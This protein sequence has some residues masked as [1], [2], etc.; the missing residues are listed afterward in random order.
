[1]AL[2][3]QGL[4]VVDLSRLLPGPFA[5]MVL[6]G[7]GADVVKVE[8]PQGG[9]WLRGLPPL[10]GDASGPFHALNRGKRSLALDIGRPEGARALLG[11]ARRADAVVESFRPGVLD[12]LGAGYEALRRENPRI[13]L[14]SITGYGQDGPYAR[15]AGHD[16]DYCAV[17]G[18]LAENGPPERPLPFGV[19]VADVAGGAW[20]AVAGILAALL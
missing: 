5:T 9:D 14:C 2:P 10:A 17:A 11:L 8:P 18:A 12:A 4:L 16:I 7:L 19:Q 1:M 20:P 3:L 6:A 13:V 15:R